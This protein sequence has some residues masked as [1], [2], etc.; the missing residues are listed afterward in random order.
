MG[1]LHN[2]N[3]LSTTGKRAPLLT[4][5]SVQTQSLYNLE[6]DPYGEI[7][8]GWSFNPRRAVQPISDLGMEQQ[9]IQGKVGLLRARSSNDKKSKFSTEQPQSN[10]LST[11]SSNPPITRGRTADD[12]EVQN[13]LRL[14]KCV[15]LD[16]SG[17][18]E[19]EEFIH[20]MKTDVEVIEIVQN[21]KLLRPLLKQ[22]VFE[23]HFRTMDAD[24]SDEVTWEE[25]RD[26]CTSEALGLESAGESEKVPSKGHSY[27]QHHTSIDERRQQQMQSENYRKEQTTILK[28]VF[29]L[30]D[31]DNSGLIDQDELLFAMSHDSKVTAFANESDALQPL[32]RNDL[33]A[34]TWRAMDT[35]DDDG[36]SLEEF[37]EFCLVVKEVSDLNQGVFG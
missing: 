26:F 2:F 11:R 17:V 6:Q 8:R 31:K 16:H 15:D 24:D 12:G 27:K 35:D 32:L 28:K 21:S 29:K 25:F 7:R 18:I 10:V 1:T 4:G 3:P 13:L 23:A 19:K 34:K 14:F 9:S 36:V 30:I 5:T 33:F 20:A 37:V 22:N